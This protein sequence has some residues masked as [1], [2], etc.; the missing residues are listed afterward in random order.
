MDQEQ[1]PRIVDHFSDIEDPRIERNKLHKLIDIITIAICAVICNA[2]TWEDIEEFAKSKE[3]WFR[4]FLELPHGVP[5]HD[6]LRRVFI[7]LK[8]EEFQAG[9]LSWLRALR[10]LLKDKEVEVVSID[11]K[12]AR[13]SF[14]THEGMPAMHMV[15]AWANH[16]SMV[17]AQLRVQ[18]KPNEDRCHSRVAEA[19]GVGRLCGDHRCDGL[20]EADRKG[21]S[22]ERRRVCACAERES[23]H[24]A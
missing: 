5:S 4:K 2:D 15:S 1:S 22:G 23:R 3:G 14:D 16:S 24:L 20:P 21:H 10:A 11:G 19:T 18:E 8:P 9:F 7:R 6:T 12:T 17:L 13:R